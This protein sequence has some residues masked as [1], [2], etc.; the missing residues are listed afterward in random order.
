MN[1][2]SSAAIRRHGRRAAG[3]SIV[4]LLVALTI[5]ALLLTATMLAIDASFRA[6]AD[7]AEQASTQ[8]ATRM[9]TNRL[10]TLIR[11]STAHGP[12]AADAASNPPVTISGDII[13]S[14]YMELLDPNDNIVRIEY[15]S[16]TQELWLIRDPG[17]ADA[18]A[19]PLLA[20]VTNA[21]FVAKR[22]KDSS[23]VYVLERGT[24]DLTVQPDNDATL[25]LENGRPQQIRIIASTKPRKLEQ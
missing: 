20:G 8:A 2:S 3:L 17:T 1:S 18:L 22:R 13:T 10:L 23:G 25:A 14:H 11:T 21:S 5:T 4:E 6:Y 15:R 16:A 19:Q 9:V 7:A 12:L 24:F